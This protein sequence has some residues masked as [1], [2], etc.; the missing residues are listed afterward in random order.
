LVIGNG[1][2]F[3][4]TGYLILKISL[5][6]TGLAFNY[7]SDSDLAIADLVIITKNIKQVNAFFNVLDKCRLLVPYFSL[8]D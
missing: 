2:G 4:S 6:L 8:P 3:D 5:Q 1:L 7:L